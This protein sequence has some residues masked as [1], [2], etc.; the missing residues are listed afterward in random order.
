MLCEPEKAGSYCLWTDKG[1][2]LIDCAESEGY[3]SQVRSGACG[4]VA[5]VAHCP[6]D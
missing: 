1:Q 2:W 6:M 4:T 5:G 3:C